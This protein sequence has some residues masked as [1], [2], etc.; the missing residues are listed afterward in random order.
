LFFKEI[1][2]LNN[3]NN[4]IKREQK[5]KINKRGEPRKKKKKKNWLKKKGSP[6]CPTINQFVENFCPLSIVSNKC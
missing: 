4:K 6:T 5:D 3:D 2:I 1:V